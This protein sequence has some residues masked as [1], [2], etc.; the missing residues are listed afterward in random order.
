MVARPCGREGAELAATLAGSTHRDVRFLSDRLIPQAG[1]KTDLI[2][3]APAA[4]W[5][6]EAGDHEGEAHV[7]ARRDRR[8]LRIGSADLSDH[9]SALGRRIELVAAAV[10]SVAPGLP[11]LGAFC[12]PR[13]E[14]PVF[15]TLTV[16]GLPIC[17]LE[18]LSKRLNVRGPVGELD[19][20]R[21][22]RDLGLHFPA[23]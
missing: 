2:A 5:V 23:C 18:A 19:V 4:V 9:V 1:L 20:V 13:A 12:F 16:A 14:L 17:D 6:V 3:I 15:R 11:T 21:F 22:A 7:C 8:E 10:A